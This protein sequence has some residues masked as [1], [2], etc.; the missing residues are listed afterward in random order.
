MPWAGGKVVGQ[1]SS[2][3]RNMR[4]RLLVQFGRL[5]LG[6]RDERGRLSYETR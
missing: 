2:L 5:N 3:G 1:A 6:K 4:I